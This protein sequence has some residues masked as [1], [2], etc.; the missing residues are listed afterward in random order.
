MPL[1]VGSAALC[2]VLVGF[3]HSV[4]VTNPL[5]N[6][7]KVEALNASGRHGPDGRGRPSQHLPVRMLVGGGVGLL[8]RGLGG[9]GFFGAEIFGQVGEDG[10]AV[11]IGDDGAEAFHFLELLGPLLAGEMLLGDASGVMAGG[12]GGFYLGL[13]GSRGKRLA[14]SAGRLGAG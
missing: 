2:S 11:G 9:S 14:G 7:A 5:T 1:R 12:A 4:L 10:G 3:T 6:H 8:G 13:H